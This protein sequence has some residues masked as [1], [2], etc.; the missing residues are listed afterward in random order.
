M[1][2]NVLRYCAPELKKW[3]EPFI[4]T[5]QTLKEPLKLS[6]IDKGIIAPLK[7]I[8][9]TFANG[10][11]FDSNKEPV[12]ESEFTTRGCQ[13]VQPNKDVLEKQIAETKLNHIDEPVL[14][15]GVLPNHFG[16][17]LLDIISRL[18][19]MFD[20]QNKDMKVALL[21]E[22]SD[23]RYLTKWISLFG[24]PLDKIL[25]VQ[26]PVQFE[27]VY[28]PQPALNLYMENSDTPNGYAHPVVKDIYSRILENV[29]GS[30]KFP[31]KKVYFSRTKFSNGIRCFG[32]RPLENIFAKNGYHVFYPET[33]S[34]EDQITVV[35]NADSFACLEGT[36]Q[37]HSLF[38]KDGSELIVL[39]R[40]KVNGNNH[41]LAIN[42]LKNINYVPVS[43][44]IDFEASKTAS[45]NAF[46]PHLVGLTPQLESFFNDRRFLWSEEDFK[47][48]YE[49][50]LNYIIDVG[51]SKRYDM[52]KELSIRAGWF[53]QKV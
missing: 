51:R 46:I 17:L 45:G 35:R 16:H 21:E 23:A 37:H 1:P 10:G 20:Q 50:Y 32:E 9:E 27:K 41:Q 24:I 19:P 30:P 11:V 53:P 40:S 34:E 38:M 42:R 22:T 25:L 33:M 3:L 26:E 43:A 8:N 15:L 49:T 47:F 14:Y 29:S 48:D 6:I 2:N 18:W 52:N 39:Q 13:F 28:V 4:N 36:L 12:K 7:S 5:D 44:S 31:I